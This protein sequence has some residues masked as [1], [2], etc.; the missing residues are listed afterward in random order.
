ME[1]RLTGTT[2]IVGPVGVGK[3]RLTANTLSRWIDTHG[4]EGVVVLDFAPEIETLDGLIGGRIN[5][6][7]DV[8]AQVWYGSIDAIGPRTEGETAEE[9]IELAAANADQAKQ[10]IETAPAD[11]RAVFI[12]DITIA[13]QSADSTFDQLEGY[14]ADATCVVMN[15]F[16]GDS[17]GDDDPITL[18]ERRALIR[19]RKWADHVLELPSHSPST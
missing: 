18:A 5:R 17:F 10:L 14:S 13:L 15:A 4:S 1:V 12:N 11:P 2:L 9:S 3:T 19:L 16:E 7:V 8:P 6:F